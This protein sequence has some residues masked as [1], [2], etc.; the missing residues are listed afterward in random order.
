MTYSTVP[1][2]AFKGTGN[3]WKVLA[4]LRSSSDF[5]KA[6]TLAERTGFPYSI[7][8]V[9]LRRAISELIQLSYPIISGPKGFRLASDKESLLLYVESLEARKAGIDKRISALKRCL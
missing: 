2:S 1:K 6:K 9:E 5:V 4:L 3:K 7:T 8:F